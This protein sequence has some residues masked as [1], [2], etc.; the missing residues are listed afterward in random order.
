MTNASP[1]RALLIMG[2][3]AGGKT[4]LALELAARLDAVI[5]NADSM[6]VYRDLRVITARPSPDEEAQAPHRLFGFVDAAERY[7]VGRW[8]DAARTA[9]A[10]A[11]A[12]GKIPILV[13]GT[14]LYFKALTEGLAPAPA[15]DSA[16]RARLMAE[17]R[18]EG[19]AALH[20]RLQALDPEAAA[21]IRPT[22]SVRLLRALEVAESGAKLSELQRQNDAP[23]ENWAGLALVPDRKAL[24]SKIDAR[25]GQMLT[26]GALE[27]VRALAARGLDPL[28][29]AMKAHGVPWL[30]QHLEGGLSLAAAADLARRDTRRY[31]KRQFTWIAHQMGAWPKVVATDGQE[32]LK[33]V[34]DY[35]NGAPMGSNFPQSTG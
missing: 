12:A 33:I 14:G 22:D 21:R 24:Y 23:I 34:M 19:G 11:R 4:A 6:Q 26:D 27:E 3:T 28:L 8:R 25:F 9:I 13:G 2:P 31:A 17:W 18:E 16:T 10:D 35:L 15:A 29:P 5:I 1:T 30:I 32:R 7:S 20:E